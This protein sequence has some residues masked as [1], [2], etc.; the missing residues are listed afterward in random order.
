MAE[1]SE[2]TAFLAF[3]AGWAGGR[4]PVYLD[5]A[6]TPAAYVQAGHRDRLAELARRWDL[7]ESRQVEIGLPQRKAGA[8][9]VNST[10][11]WAWV[12]SREQVDWLWRRFRPLPSIVL[13][14]G[15]SCR[16]LCLWALQ[17][18]IPYVLAENAN[19]RLAYALHAPQKYAAPERLRIPLP[20]TFLRVGRKRP[21]PVLVTRMET[22][23]FARA[24]VVGELREPPAP[25]M[26][27]LREGK[28]KRR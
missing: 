6:P 27:R 5:A 10:V 9:V 4:F 28:V 13:R 19:R 26:Q 16:R 1:A 8:G 17:E 20:G 24:R 22:E 15:G 23:T 25:Y 11:L 14:M 21:C 18:D 7:R 2:A 3:A 12:E